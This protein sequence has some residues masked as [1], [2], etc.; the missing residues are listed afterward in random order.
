MADV[1]LFPDTVS[2]PSGRFRLRRWVEDDAERLGA[3]IAASIE[4]LRPWMAW[5]SE[6]PMSHD[7]RRALIRKWDELH[8]TGRETVYGVIAVDAHGAEGEAIGGSGLHRRSTD[9]AGRVEIGY[10]VA[11][12]HAGRGIATEVAAALTTAAFTTP[13]ITEVAIGHVASNVRSAR[14]PEKLGFTK[15]DDP[16]PAR[17]GQPE[18]TV[19]WVIDR[20]T[21]AGA[22]RH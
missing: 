18:P 16:D 6:E 22:G 21:W 15:L 1:P 9:D 20:A 4:H 10:W 5:I 19:L 17:H 12:A 8:R 13:G 3:A 14:V 11:A 2:T 7:D